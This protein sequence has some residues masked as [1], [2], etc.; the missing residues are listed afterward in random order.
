[1][2]QKFLSRPSFHEK[3]EIFKKKFFTSIHHQWIGENL[4]YKKSFS[5]LIDSLSED[6]LD[7]FTGKKEVL[8]MKS[9]GKLACSLGDITSYNIVIVY[10]D[11]CQLL[12]SAL[13]LRGIAVLAHEL[14]HLYHNHSKLE[15]SPLE[16]QVQAD[17]FALSLGFGHELQDVLLE[18]SHS[19]DCRTRIACLVSSLL[20]SSNEKTHLG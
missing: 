17:H 10:P 5:F 8:F 9:S 2:W 13:Y 14:G 12:R 20:T 15:I 11:L 19:L 18:H 6:H 16:A 7:F 1:M 3:K 4:S